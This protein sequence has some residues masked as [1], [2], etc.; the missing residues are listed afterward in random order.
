M[1]DS[2]YRGRFYAASVGNGVFHYAAV[3]IANERFEPVPQQCMPGPRR[4]KKAIAGTLIIPHI[5]NFVCQVRVASPSLVAVSVLG[6]LLGR[7][8]QVLES[9]WGNANLTD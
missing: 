2:V 6:K 3:I 1:H 4:G 8:P 7:T 9:V 5:Y